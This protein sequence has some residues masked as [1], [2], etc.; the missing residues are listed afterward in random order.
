MSRVNRRS[1]LRTL[2][3]SALAI[4][5]V[6]LLAACSGG[7]AAISTP[8]PGAAKAP[9]AAQPTATPAGATTSASGSATPTAVAQAGASSQVAGSIRFFARGDQAIFNVFHQIKDAFSKQ[10][11]SVQVTIDE[12][13]GDFYQKFQLQLASGNPPDA[14]F[15][16]D[17]TIGTSVRKNVLEPL[18]E[19]L[20]GEKAYRPDDFWS[21]AFY[22]STYGGKKWGLPYDGG[23]VVLY[24][25]QD[26]FKAAG[27]PNLDPKTPATWDQILE[28]ARRLTLDMNGKHP[29]EPGFDPK[30]IKQYGFDPS[31]GYW[32]VY[33][34]GAGGEVISKDGQVPIDSPEAVSGLQWLADL[35]TKHY[36]SPSPAFQQSSPIS[37][38]TGNVAIVYDGVWSSVRYRQNKFA[39]DVAPFPTGKKQVS[40]GWYSPLSIIAASKAKDAAWQWIWF[41][42]STP[43]Q[44]IV[45]GL[46]QDVPTI[47]AL[48][49]SDAFLNPKVP[50]EHKQVFLD[51]MSGDILRVPGDTYGS[52]FGGY[53]Q[54]F[55]QIF[56]KSFDPVWIGKRTAE[57]AAKEARPKLEKLL[58]TG[59]VTFSGPCSCST[60]L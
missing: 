33:I 40:T 30:K 4:P 46:G 28:I 48:A 5:G 57:D 6:A 29:G 9:P 15:E 51:Q 26:L 53:V 58:K 19:R 47:K 39:W 17:C 10:N 21:I 43:G 41:C 42:C 59:E 31:R 22:A 56:G 1:L 2:G 32:Q 27:V 34:W 7:G 25:N 23:S 12:V 38:N 16:C 45:S 55:R 60:V 49:Q 18:D 8:S 11:P 37:F 52:Y 20:R 44:T 50:P 36:V 54:E 14:I 24:Y 3:V 13:P 35:G